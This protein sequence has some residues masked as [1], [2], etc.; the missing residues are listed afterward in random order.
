MLRRIRP[1]ASL[2][3]A[4]EPP[5]HIGFGLARPGLLAWLGLA[6]LGWA[7]AR[8]GS[9]WPGSTDLARLGIVVINVCGHTTLRSSFKGPRTLITRRWASPARVPRS[10]GVGGEP[11]PG[12]AIIRRW[13]S[14]A[15]GS[16]TPGRRP[17]GCRAAAPVR[18]DSE[19]AASAWPPQDAC[20]HAELEPSA[21]A[22]T[23]K[24]GG[25]L[26]ATSALARRKPRQM[27]PLERIARARGDSARRRRHRP[28]RPG[29]GG[30]A[31]AARWSA[32]ASAGRTGR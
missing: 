5:A 17:S 7:Q 15:L 11:C 8:L 31:A 18:P 13:A 32:S 24:L 26:S 2:S 25:P 21:P 14:P 12:P 6:R 4:A 28:P 19:T 23:Q 30:S 9:A 27:P 22:L 16:A 10:P 29:P 1:P 3:W 20:G